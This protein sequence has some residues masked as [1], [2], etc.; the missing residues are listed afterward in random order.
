VRDDVFQLNK[1]VDPYRV[2]LS[3]DLEENLNFHVIENTLVNVDVEEFNDILRTNRHAQVD[4]DDDNDG[5]NIED[6]DKD[7]KIKEEEEDNSD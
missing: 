6:C 3:N 2:A 5:I 1:L 4:K 7:D